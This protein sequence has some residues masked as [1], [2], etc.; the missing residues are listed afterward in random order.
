MTNTTFIGN[1][2]SFADRD[3]LS[4]YKGYKVVALQSIGDGKSKVVSPHHNAKGHELSDSS[5]CWR[6]RDKHHTFEKCTCGFYSY[7]TVPDAEKHW[8]KVCGGYSNHVLVEVA[9]SG[10]VAVCEFGFR[11]SQQRI[12][13]ILFPSCWNCSNAGDR[14]VEHK[15]G[16]FVA[17]CNNCLKKQRKVDAGY[18]FAEFSALNSLEGFAPL[19]VSSVSKFSGSDAEEFFNALPEVLV[20]DRIGFLLEELADKGDLQGIDSV[21]QKARA[22]LTDSLNQ[23]S[24]DD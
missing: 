1:D 2:K 10:K 9:V 11:S 12:A 20:T 22:L 14:V 13:K 3:K 23:N 18:S 19:E 8:S 17:A 4:A 6:D 5:I 24:S 16:Y 21:I 15:S 7:D